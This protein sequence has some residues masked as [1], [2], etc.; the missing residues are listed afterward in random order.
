MK[1][2]VIVKSIS[3]TWI[4][5]VAMEPEC[6]EPLNLV[7]KKDNN[8]SSGCSLNDEH[9]PASLK[10]IE[11]DKVESSVSDNMAILQDSSETTDNSQPMTDQKILTALHMSNL[12]QMSNMNLPRGISPPPYGSQYYFMQLLA[13]VEAQQIMC[14]QMNWSV[15]QHFIRNPLRLPQP[16]FDGPTINITEQLCHSPNPTSA[17]LLPNAKRESINHE[18]KQSHSKRYY[19][20]NHKCLINHFIYIYIQRHIINCHIF[21]FAPRSSIDQKN[22]TS[23]SADNTKTQDT[24]QQNNQGNNHLF[25]LSPDT[26]GYIINFNYIINVFM[27]R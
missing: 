16:Y 10:N 26:L 4:F 15:P 12:M 6:L 23:L 5:C 11:E 17:Y 20:S 2:Q 27:N 9:I 14:Q 3:P 19:S 8:N 22:S 7:I 21:L 1:C 25:L 18:T 13:M 24:G